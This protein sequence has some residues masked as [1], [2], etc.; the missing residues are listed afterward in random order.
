VLADLSYIALGL[1][2]VVAVL[3]VVVRGRSGSGDRARQ[4]WINEQMA[5]QE[6]AHPGGRFSEDEYLA[7]LEAL[8]ERWEAGEGRSPRTWS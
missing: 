3:V 1:V 5:R 6:A 4:D 7:R 8:E 2:V